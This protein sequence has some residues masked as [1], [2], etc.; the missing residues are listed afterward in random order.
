MITV[1]EWNAIFIGKKETDAKHPRK[2]QPLSTPDALEGT[3]F[4]LPFPLPNLLPH[5][6]LRSLAL[7]LA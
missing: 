1:D 2:T 6:H 4:Y 3:L 5:F 7:A